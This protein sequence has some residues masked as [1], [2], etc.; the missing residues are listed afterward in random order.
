[1]PP[2]RF[3]RLAA[4]LL[5]K[6]ID[7]DSP[8]VAGLMADL[9]YGESGSHGRRRP[10]PSTPER[11]AEEVAGDLRKTGDGE[12]EALPLFNQ[13]QP[14][15]EQWF[16]I[17]YSYGEVAGTIRLRRQ[18][19]SRRADRL[20]LT[21]GGP[22]S[23]VLSRRSSGYTLQAFCREEAL[24]PQARRGWRRTA[25]KLQN[26]GVETDDTIRGDDG[27]DGFSLPWEAGPYQR[28]DTEG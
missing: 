7:L 24:S 15:G 8:G 10:W 16:V 21:T 5:E 25:Q 6:G 27:F 11:L 9:A 12:A 1:M 18:P 4:M 2:Q 17:P 13:L 26:L 23:F 28:V 22:W 3:A 19:Q 14:G 20:V